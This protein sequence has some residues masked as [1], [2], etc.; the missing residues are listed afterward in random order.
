MKEYD[1]YVPLHSNTGAPIPV[2]KLTRLKRRLIERF[3]GLTQ[4]PQAHDGFWKIGAVTFR[5]RIIILRVLSNE[6]TN[7]SDRFWSQVKRSL[8]KQ[9]KQQDVLIVVKQVTTI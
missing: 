2:V 4:F 8:K 9:W 5:D 6:D 3:G 1:L 7:A